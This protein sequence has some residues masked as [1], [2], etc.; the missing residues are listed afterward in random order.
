MPANYGGDRKEGGIKSFLKKLRKVEQIASD[1]F[2]LFLLFSPLF[3]A[4]G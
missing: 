4:A 1:N 2:F 3:L